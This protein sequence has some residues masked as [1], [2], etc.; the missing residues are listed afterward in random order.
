[1]FHDDEL[2]DVREGIAMCTECGLEH[3]FNVF[4]GELLE[5]KHPE[6]AAELKRQSEEDDE[7][8]DDEE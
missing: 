4:L 8:E 5:G 6:L 7:E 2:A 3:A 1:V